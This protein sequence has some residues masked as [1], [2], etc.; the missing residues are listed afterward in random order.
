MQNTKF[1]TAKKQANILSRD[2]FSNYY[3]TEIQ[4]IKKI[5]D[6]LST[7]IYVVS[8]RI[9]VVIF[10]FLRIALVKI[11]L[12]NSIANNLKL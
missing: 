10:T 1:D 11:N 2:N 7:Y 5:T 3:A 4:A 8:L 9:Y 6:T 12:Y